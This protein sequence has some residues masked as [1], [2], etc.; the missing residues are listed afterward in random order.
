MLFFF[1]IPQFIAYIKGYQV[2]DVFRKVDLYPFLFACACHGFFIVCAW[3]GNHAFVPYADI[4]QHAMILTLLVP[5]LRRRIFAPTMVGVGL[6]LTGSLMNRA[7]INAN[8]GKMPVYPTLSEWIGFYKDGQ[9]NGS[10]DELHVLMD[11]SSRLPF[12]A[13]YIDIGLCIMSPGDVLIHS[14]AS[15]IIYYTITSVCAPI[16]QTQERLIL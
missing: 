5:I 9:L 13:D 1:L 14:F 8:G 6:T 12:L 7:V 11:S 2:L 10:I 4:L 3:N 15:I 16:E